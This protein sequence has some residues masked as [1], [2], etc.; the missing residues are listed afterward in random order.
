MAID[1]RR[2]VMAFVG[3]AQ[4]G[5]VVVILLLST[6]LTLFAGSHQDADGHLVNNFLN[7]NTLMQVATETST[8][9][10]MA[11]GATMVIITA[12]IDLAQVREG[13]GGCA[14][15]AQ[16][17]RARI[18]KSHPSRRTLTLPWRALSSATA[19]RSPFCCIRRSL[20]LSKPRAAAISTST[21]ASPDVR[22]WSTD[23]ERP[24]EHDRDAPHRGRR[25]HRG[26]GGPPG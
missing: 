23:R 13:I 16:G 3:S 25:S 21:G 10:I 20:R 17:P 7:P 26:P 24:G 11:V 22:W 4:F 12:G 1:M 5:L 15:I 14:L 9:A 6:L 8:F 19:M 18:L 2:R